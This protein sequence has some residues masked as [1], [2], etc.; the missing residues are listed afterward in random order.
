MRKSVLVTGASGYIGSL[1]IER[2]AADKKNFKTIVATDV[3][4]Y[5][6]EKRKPGI[7]YIALDIR[8]P[9]VAE[10]FKKYQ[11][12]TVVHL[13]SIVTPPKG[14][15]REVIYDIDVNGTENL[16][17]ACIAYGTKK[18]IVTSSGAAY[19]YWPDNSEWLSENDPIRGN[20]VF[21]YSHHKKLVEQMLAR[22][23]EEHPDL[24]QVIFRP[25]TILG[26]DTHNQ[27]TNIWEQ[28]KVTGLKG[29][30]T[31]F[32]LIWDT[33]VVNILLQ[34]IHEE[35]E[36]IFNL[37]GDGV[38]TLKEIADLIGKPYRE[39]PVWLVKLALT[40]GSKLGLTQY[41]PEQIIYLQ[42][43]PV[44]DNK[45]LKEGFGYIPEKTTR[46]VFDFHLAA[47]K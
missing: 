37:A 1:T 13:A 40:I 41:G 20:E 6:Q 33:D 12:D 44:L 11:I 45:N 30:K 15:T 29:S 28:D 23:R 5:P 31:P 43:R 18:F 39:L 9:E 22:Y 26:A 25:G 47:Q 38:L 32:V 14:M 36:G 46:E 24:Q 3:R 42:Y 10:V 2:L 35:N 21:A 27:I 4:E 34:A 7:E 17:K 8:A 16:L 19:G